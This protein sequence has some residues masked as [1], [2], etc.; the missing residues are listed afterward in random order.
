MGSGSRIC[1]LN[2]VFIARRLIYRSISKVSSTEDHLISLTAF[3]MSWEHAFR[4]L[5]VDF[6]RSS[7]DF[8]V[9][10]HNGLRKRQDKISPKASTT[11]FPIPPS[12]SPTPTRDSS[13][14][15]I[16]FQYLD[17]AI[18]PPDLPGPDELTL[19]SPLL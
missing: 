5:T 3:Q 7:A 9:R 15:N 8:V 2:F 1:E 19:I 12:S 14:A 10:R 4:S 11:S 17:Q 16:E 18:L 13:R 6:G